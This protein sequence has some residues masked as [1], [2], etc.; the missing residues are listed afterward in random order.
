M[1]FRNAFSVLFD[2]FW[3]KPRAI[4]KVSSYKEVEAETEPN[5][6]ELPPVHRDSVPRPKNFARG[7]HH[8]LREDGA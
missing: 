4:E 8:P 6:G 7:D 5:V 3:R 2:D 1:S